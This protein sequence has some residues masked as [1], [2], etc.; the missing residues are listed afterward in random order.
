MA[1]GLRRR[2]FV[3]YF[4]W[5]VIIKLMVWIG[6]PLRV[7]RQGKR[8]IRGALRPLVYERQL[9]LDS[10]SALPKRQSARGSSPTVK[11]GSAV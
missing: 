6:K 2:S 11:E 5:D 1:S 3:D 10:Q 9:V 7:V 4:R 8:S